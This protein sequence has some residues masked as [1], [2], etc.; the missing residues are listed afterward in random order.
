MGIQLTDTEF[1]GRQA[2]KEY[3]NGTILPSAFK[4]CTTKTASRNIEILLKQNK[5][6]MLL[7]SGE[8]RHASKDDRERALGP[9][10]TENELYS[11]DGA[12]F[13]LRASEIG[14]YTAVGQRIMAVI[15]Y[16]AR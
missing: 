14:M 15:K 13:C 4:R 6:W 2:C 8:L 3:Y 9:I 7:L 1:I 5:N 10:I 12:E 16:F 11:I